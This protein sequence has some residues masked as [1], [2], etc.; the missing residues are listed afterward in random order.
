MRHFLSVTSQESEQRKKL[1]RYI[2]FTLNAYKNEEGENFVGQIH[3]QSDGK[4]I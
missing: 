4:N 3:E 1:S 2:G